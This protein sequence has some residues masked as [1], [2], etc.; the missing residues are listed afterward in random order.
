MA[1]ET[2]VIGGGLAGLAA[3]AALAERALPVTL[4][5]SRPRLGGRASSFFD[6][7]AGTSID[8]CQHVSMGCCTNFQEFCRTVG[9]EEDFQRQRTLYFVGPD[10]RVH[11][12]RAGWLPAPLHLWTGFR[13]LGYLS[14]DDKSC[15]ARGLRAL[16]QAEKPSRDAGRPASAHSGSS[17][18]RCNDN[19][20]RSF[21][22]WLRTN[23]QTTAA[24]N[25]FWHV[26]L[27][28]ALS[29]SL[30]RIDVG[31]AR[32]V[33]VDAFLSNRRGWE[34]QIPTAPLDALYGTKLT[35]WFSRH[36]V[37]IWLQ[38]G[39][40]RL[41]VEGDRAVGVEL[42]DGRR[43]TAD[44]FILAVP[45]DRV[46][47]LLPERVARHP[48]VAGLSNLESAPISSVHLWFDRQ[49]TDLPH[50]VFVERLSQWMF[51]R[52]L[53]QSQ[54]KQK[55]HR[56]TA[57][58]WPFLGIRPP[59]CFCVDTGAAGPSL[60]SRS[61]Y[62][63]IVISAS[64]NLQAM[65]QQEVI[66]AVVRELADVWPTAGQAR[67]IHGRMVTE[68]RAVISVTP[69]SERWRPG[70]QSPV[71]NLQF[72]GDWTRTGWPPTMEGAVR[73]GYLAAENVLGELGMAETLLAPDLPTAL[74]S[75]MI[76]RL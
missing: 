46:A 8:N 72:A 30:D 59:R 2:I 35:E 24:V 22:D 53:L 23:G 65:S 47:P 73:S 45:H 19:A 58:T 17:E 15:V 55:P 76:L 62:Y 28:S 52:T 16:A 41:L 68:H 75:K 70:Q 4:L 31:T 66:D 60:D 57:T 74:L 48:D 25:R 67:L 5:E 9:L 33:F 71:S 7:T 29:E 38:A 42:R 18:H 61:H 64:R 14:P 49:I 39:V 13:R 56:D 54:T 21:A 10:R 34:V 36:G 11:R 69:D 43:L 51:N 37:S 44:Q 27:V 50:A 26:V 6:R 40:R 1:A 3:A 12:L 20:C 63:Q 32:K